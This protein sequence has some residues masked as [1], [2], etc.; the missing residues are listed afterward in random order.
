MIGITDCSFICR[1][2]RN[3]ASPGQQYL[4][5]IT[6]DE[7]HEFASDMGKKQTFREAMKSIQNL[8]DLGTSI[9]LLTGTMPPSTWSS[10][11]SYTGFKDRT[12][13]FVKVRCN[14]IRRDIRYLVLKPRDRTH[15][16]RAAVGLTKHAIATHVMG[17]ARD[18]PDWSAMIFCTSVR[19][20]E[21]LHDLLKDAVDVGV[22][23]YHG[24]HKDNLDTWTSGQNKIVVTTTA[25]GPGI[26]N[27]TVRLVLVLGHLH[28]ATNI[29]QSGSR[30]G[31]DKNGGLVFM[32]PES[33]NSP[34]CPPPSEDIQGMSA[35]LRLI[36]LPQC[37]LKALEEFFDGHAIDEIASCSENACDFC[38]PDFV[39]PVEMAID[40]YLNGGG[41]SPLILHDT[42]V[43]EAST[44]RSDHTH[45]PA[46]VQLVSQVGTI[47]LDPI[48]SN[49]NTIDGQ[50][51]Q[52]HSSRTRITSST[53]AVTQRFQLVRQRS[54]S[55]DQDLRSTKRQRSHI[56]GAS[57]QAEDIMYDDID[58][59][60]ATPLASGGRIASPD[61]DEDEELDMRILQ[62]PILQPV[63]DLAIHEDNIMPAARVAENPMAPEQPQ[64]NEHV[65]S[66]QLTH[67]QA[68]TVYWLEDYPSSLYAA[69]EEKDYEEALRPVRYNPMSQS[70]RPSRHASLSTTH[71][72]PAT[73][74]AT[75]HASSSSSRAPPLQPDFETVL[76][77][78]SLS[79]HDPNISLSCPD[80]GGLGAHSLSNNHVTSKS[81]GPNS[82][83]SSP[84]GATSSRSVITHRRSA[85]SDTH[86]PG[87]APL[88]Q[89]N[90]KAH[91]SVVKH[92]RTASLPQNVLPPGSHLQYQM[93]SEPKSI[94]QPPVLQHPASQ[95]TF[96]Q[97][98][99]PPLLASQSILSFP[100]SQQLFTQRPLASQHILGT[101]DF[102]N[103][104]ILPV[105][106]GSSL[107]HYP[108]S[109]QLEDD[110]ML[111]NITETHRNIKHL[112]HGHCLMCLIDTQQLVQLSDEKNHHLVHD[113][114]YECSVARK[115]KGVPCPFPAQPQFWEWKRRLEIDVSLLDLCF[116]CRLP[117]SHPVGSNEDPPVPFHGTEGRGYKNCPNGPLLLM[118]LWRAWHLPRLSAP[119][120]HD[121][122]TPLHPHLVAMNIDEFGQWCM[123]LRDGGSR[124][125]N[126]MFLYENWLPSIMIAA[127]KQQPH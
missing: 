114:W 33:G 34:S 8:L 31:R 12:M 23:Y 110:R 100:L 83:K 54:I 4:A 73:R 71:P 37:R 78:V 2:L 86:T 87:I 123:K 127:Q 47:Y 122:Y 38:D 111:K 45:R 1:Y 19:D 113:G 112:V 51:A 109:A 95:P 77:H 30:A 61:S 93:P 85:S 57:Q 16:H 82:S 58:M 28:G 55:S 126:G 69:V 26:Q 102:A 17:V 5:R 46:D 3:A 106:K 18:H 25:L 20:V 41:T 39:E 105:M 107:V 49:R 10:F 68:S 62:Q 97:P 89:R 121:N 119:A 65:L 56:G 96:P 63:S 11:L 84:R 94:S 50:Q 52:P 88:L 74:L 67:S 120:I 125:I 64:L 118:F 44:S 32:I 116:D 117:R 98:V 21:D 40:T 99:A 60:P 79:R 115:R 81:S 9:T 104:R 43:L 80:L 124:Y 75:A 7:A 42:L 72:P 6:I 22:T 36:H 103:V 53:H 92:S 29:M 48:S 91:R 59:C 24:K 70:R 13:D 35:Y 27:D 14:S 15:M 76:Q 101:G 66:N 108:E 90:H